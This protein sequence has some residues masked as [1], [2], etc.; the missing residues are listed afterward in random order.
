VSDGKGGGLR[1]ILALALIA[2]GAFNYHRN[3]EAERAAQQPRS[4]AHYSDTSLEQLAGAYAKALEDQQGELQRA[5]S[6]RGNVSRNRRLG[7][8]VREMERVQQGTRAE[9]DAMASVAESEAR[10]RAIGAEIAI[11]EREAGSVLVHL[12]RLTGLA[13]Q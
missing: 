11:R 6:R 2:G 10:L 13:L 4:F 3:L 7:D 8:A 5:R 12:E 1:W 9:R